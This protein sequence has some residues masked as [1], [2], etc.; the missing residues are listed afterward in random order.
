MFGPERFASIESPNVIDPG[1]APPMQPK[2]K[3]QPPSSPKKQQ[4]AGE[5]STPPSY[6]ATGL[7]RTEKIA[8]GYDQVGV[9]DDL[10]VERAGR[11]YE[12]GDDDEE[13]EDDVHHSL[14]SIDEARNYAATLLVDADKRTSKR[15]LW[16]TE[17][18]SNLPTSSHLPLHDYQLSSSSSSKH[19]VRNQVVSWL[20]KGL[21]V[22]LV[23]VLVVLALGRLSS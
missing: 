20:A 21:C 12:D 15:D 5:S 2:R 6:R 7:G 19:L 8:L 16:A 22:V 23:I 10:D 13:E 18:P 4:T 9:V 1:D 14:P 17:Q 11:S 3:Q